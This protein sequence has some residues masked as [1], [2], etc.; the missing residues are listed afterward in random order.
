MNEFVRKVFTKQFG[1]KFLIWVGICVTLCGLTIIGPEIAPLLVV[2]G[3]ASFFTVPLGILMLFIVPIW[4]L[5]APNKHLVTALQ[6]ALLM[7]GLPAV[8]WTTYMF[9]DELYLTMRSEWRYKAAEELINELEDYKRQHQTY[10]VSTGKVPVEFKS[11]EE[12]RNKHI[13]YASQGRFFRIY[14]D[15]PSRLFTINNYT[16]CSD[17]S[18]LPEGYVVGKPTDRLN[19]RLMSRAD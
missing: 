18:Q 17:W 12:C 3:I 10:P 11:S 16:Y 14:F 1:K 8:S 7:I 2:C 13:G 15:L 4:Y 6:L 19:W 5:L 9:G